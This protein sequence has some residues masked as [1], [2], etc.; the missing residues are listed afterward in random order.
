MAASL[1]LPAVE[2]LPLELL[3]SSFVCV[4]LTA[5]LIETDWR[6]GRTRS[7]M[8]WGLSGF[9][10]GLVS[11]AFN[12]LLG[13]F[14]QLVE[15]TDITLVLVVA[16]VAN[17]VDACNDGIDKLVDVYHLWADDVFNLELDSIAQSVAPDCFDMAIVS[18]IAFRGSI[19][20]PT[21]Y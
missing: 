1:L 6:M 20:I 15:V 12:H 18:A 5:L 2:C 13:C 9:F 21:V 4:A 14:Q 10:S 17:R 3:V 16:K 8:C 19:Q 11:V 7:N